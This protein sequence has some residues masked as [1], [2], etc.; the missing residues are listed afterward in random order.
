LIAVAAAVVVLLV[1]AGEWGNLTNVRTGA[2]DSVECRVT[3]YEVGDSLI[4]S[5]TT[6]TVPIEVNGTVTFTTTGTYTTISPGSS[7]YPTYTY[8]GQ[9]YTTSIATSRT[10]TFTVTTSSWDSGQEPVDVWS[11]TTCTYA[12]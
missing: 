2:A 7:A 10:G 1:A 6:E 11:L 4:L 5:S 8:V 3:T 9:N 12:P